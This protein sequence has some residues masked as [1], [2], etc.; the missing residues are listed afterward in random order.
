M[1][2]VVIKPAR[3]GDERRQPGYELTEQ[4]MVGRNIDAMERQNYIR[5]QD[6]ARTSRRGRRNG[7]EHE[8]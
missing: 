2:W 5:W 4:D 7:D 1:G 6:E 3:I 8:Q